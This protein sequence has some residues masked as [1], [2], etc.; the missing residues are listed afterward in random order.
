M[1]VYFSQKKSPKYALG[2]FNVALHYN[3]RANTLGLLWQIT[4]G[5]Y[6][7]KHSICPY[8]I[9]YLFILKSISLYFRIRQKKPRLLPIGAV[10]ITN[11]QYIQTNSF[12]N[13]LCHF[14]PLEQS[15]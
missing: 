15:F 13:S 10:Y 3:V 8:T 11:L 5:F 1:Q 12:R 7:R 14:A 2:L 9:T 4:K 6:Y